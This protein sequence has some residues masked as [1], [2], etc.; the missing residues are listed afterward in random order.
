MQEGK[1]RISCGKAVMSKGNYLEIDFHFLFFGPLV[2]TIKN[3]L[4]YQ[5]S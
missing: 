3:G 1:L 4:L 2:L 5:L